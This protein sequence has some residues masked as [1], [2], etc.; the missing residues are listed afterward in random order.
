M[1]DENQSQEQPESQKTGEQVELKL[2]LSEVVE[3]SV[4]ALDEIN[5][6]QA[7]KELIKQLYESVVNYKKIID[8][9]QEK[10][11]V[12]NAEVYKNIEK[13]SNLVEIMKT[14]GNWNFSSYQFGYANGLL[15][16]LSIMLGVDYKP[17]EKPSEWLGSSL[18]D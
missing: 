3:K 7:L 16:A 10:S 17:L 15:L 2:G 1:T 5:D 4:S 6:V 8:S 11:D 13:L 9:Y 18:I 14:D 12:Q